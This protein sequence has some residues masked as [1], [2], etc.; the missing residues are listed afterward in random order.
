[1]ATTLSHSP[2]SDVPFRVLRENEFK[3]HNFGRHPHLSILQPLIEE[4]PLLI[5]TS[6]TMKLYISSIV[7]LLASLA[8]GI[9]AVPIG[10]GEHKHVLGTDERMLRLFVMALKIR[11]RGVHNFVGSSARPYATARYRTEVR[12]AGREGG[13]LKPRYLKY[14]N[15]ER[16]E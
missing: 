4:S 7:V 10:N 12:R 2:N 9:M 8:V 6:Q 11:K 3:E 15:N 14:L 16:R 5:Y 1:M 13:K